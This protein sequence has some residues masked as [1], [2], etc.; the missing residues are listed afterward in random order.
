GL[1]RAFCDGRASA[2]QG[3][4]DRRLAVV[5]RRGRSEALLRDTRPRDP[6]GCAALHGRWEANADR[7]DSLAAHRASLGTRKV[8]ERSGPS[9]LGRLV[10]AM[11]AESRGHLFVVNGGS[12]RLSWDAV[13]I[14]CDQDQEVSNWW[15]QLF[16]LNR[17]PQ[18][19][20]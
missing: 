1:R 12:T 15:F 17:N 9:V 2:L 14:P 4:E 7:L 8:E 16:E 20:W 3:V 13:L 11:R 5:D 18:H 10:A 19:A 6:F